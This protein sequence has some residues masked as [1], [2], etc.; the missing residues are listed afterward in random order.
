MPEQ[1]QQTQPVQAQPS[2]QPG[3]QP[4]QVPEKKSRWWLWLIIILIVI[5]LGVG[6]YFLL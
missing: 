3:V 1:M 6:I 4:V 2:V 5:G